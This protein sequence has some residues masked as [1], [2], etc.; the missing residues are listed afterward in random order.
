MGDSS[1][2]LIGFDGI[3]R[4]IA[5]RQLPSRDATRDQK[6]L[7]ALSSVF[8]TPQASGIPT[9]AQN[10]AALPSSPPNPMP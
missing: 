9:K 5:G 3:A 8:Q 1:D 2:L 10:N 6:I 4:S 7:T